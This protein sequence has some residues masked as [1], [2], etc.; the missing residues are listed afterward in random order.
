M[1][2]KHAKSKVD[3]EQLKL[4]VS[5]DAEYEMWSNKCNTFC[6]TLRQF[7]SVQLPSAEVGLCLKVFESRLNFV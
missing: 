5:E 7:P 3:Q 2:L 1:M 4:L 6:D